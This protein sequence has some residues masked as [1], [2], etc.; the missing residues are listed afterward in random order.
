MKQPEFAVV[1]EKDLDRVS[2]LSHNVHT[3]YHS[4]KDCHEPTTK[5]K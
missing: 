1:S 4:C 2:T 5:Y 3:F